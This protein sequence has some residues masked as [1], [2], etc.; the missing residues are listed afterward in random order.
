M[1]PSFP[2]VFVTVILGGVAVQAPAAAQQ[3]LQGFTE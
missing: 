1:R 3:D 2:V